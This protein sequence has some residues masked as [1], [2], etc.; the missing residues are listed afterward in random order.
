LAAKLLTA[1]KKLEVIP[2]I[3]TVLEKQQEIIDAETDN[4]TRKNTLISEKELL[5]EK[6]ED[7]ITAR[8]AI[9]AA[10]VTLIAAKQEL[11]TKKESLI[12][13][14]GLVATQETTNVGYLNQYI[15][16]LSG[17]SDVQQDL[18][19]AKKALIPKINEK[20][21]ALIA[22]TAELDAW[23]IVKNAIAG[24]KEDIATYME[25][26]ADKKGDVIDARVNLNTLK[27]DL[28]EAG[29]N[30]EIA[31]MTG[32]SNLMTQKVGNA[33]EMLT[34]REAAFDAKISRGSDLLSAQINLDLHQSQVAY[35][36]MQEVND[37][38]IDARTSSLSRI[39][40]A[41]I[42]EREGTADAAANAEL[43]SQLTHLL[44]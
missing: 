15:T 35:E 32:R 22:Y 9:A 13:A 2:Y 23:V 27:L 30:L 34:E 42:E 39:V 12:T 20:S 17:L 21:T 31:R 11:V 44:S 25:D 33:A 41:R 3:E 4:A 29:I 43:T 37:I 24:V 28:Q 6:R 26:R 14:K 19:A 8:E 18:V 7:L 5:N 40:L 10:I 38:E 36:T 1:E 16:A